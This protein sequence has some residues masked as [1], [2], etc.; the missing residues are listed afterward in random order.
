V[1]FSPD[2][3][4]VYAGVYDGS[5]NELDLKSRQLFKVRFSSGETGATNLVVSPLGDKL[6]FMGGGFVQL[7]DLNVERVYKK[8]CVWLKPRLPF[9]PDL[10]GDDRALCAGP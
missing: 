6:A 5:W 10:S 7:A 1:A 8:M 4:K 3:N 9:I 2:G